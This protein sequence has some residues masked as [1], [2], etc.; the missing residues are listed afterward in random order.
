MKVL[1]T[2]GAG[3]VGSHACKALAAAGHELV[4]YDNLA[5][6]RADAVRW[7]PFERGDVRDAARMAEVMRRHRPDLVMHFAALA[8]V[9][10]SMRDPGAY[11]S[12]NVGGTLTLLQTMIAAGVTKLVFSSTCATY[13]VPDELPIRET[14]PQRPVNPYGLTKQ[15]AERMLHDFQ[16]AHG[17]RWT[18][19][20]YF[21]AA[22]ADPDGEI[23]E[24]PGCEGR[25][26][27]LA[28]MAALRMGPPF[29][30]LGEDFDTPDGSAIR[31]YV[32]VSDLAEAH[33]RSAEYL[34]SGG[35]SVALNLGTG[36]GT[37]VHQ[38]VRCVAAVTG[39]DVP[40]IHAERRAGDPP[41]L[42]A[43]A[44]LAAKVL[45]WQAKHRS[46]DDIVK[47]AVRWLERGV[48]DQAA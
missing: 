12:V 33:L 4:V 44:A 46:L 29:P 35:E 25:A 15:A 27:P 45:G 5:T 13:G 43:D 38:L 36:I 24:H 8:F 9:G 31:D 37:S 11:Y 2:G 22:G 21:N 42:Y 47:T 3:F 26:I 41:C 23:G 18:A 1:V 20:R 34:M 16:R 48:T 7:G 17:L 14:T 6:G 39:R 28:I 19:L 10:A 40:V 30:I 32:H